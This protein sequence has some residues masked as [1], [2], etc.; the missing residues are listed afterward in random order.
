[1]GNVF[2]D[3]KKA[4]PLARETGPQGPEAAD[5]KALRGQSYDD[6]AKALAPDDG[7]ATASGTIVAAKGDV[8]IKLPRATD[9]EEAGPGTP[10]GAHSQVSTGDGGSATIKFADGSDL[11][12]GGNALLV[13]Y[14]GSAKNTKTRERTKTQVLTREG[15]V[16]GGLAALDQKKG[17]TAE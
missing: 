15:T 3:K 17:H 5:K 16:K 9:W 2:D 8:R 11:S 10:V 4:D 6:G 13:I 14:G 12:L 1:M 7:K